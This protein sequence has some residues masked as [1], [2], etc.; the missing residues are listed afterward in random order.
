MKKNIKKAYL[1]RIKSSRGF[2][3]NYK[4]WQ[5]EF[6]NKKRNLIVEFNKYLFIKNLEKHVFQL[7][8]FKKINYLALES[9]F[10]EK[11]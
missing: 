8:C 5:T 2:N 6:K 1:Q 7:F 9:S 3:K 10:Y 11:N 4:Q